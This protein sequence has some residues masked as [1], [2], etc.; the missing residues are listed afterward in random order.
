M[1]PY[2]KWLNA[3]PKYGAVA[4]R[5]PEFTVPHQPQNA[6]LS[7]LYSY[8]SCA[9]IDELLWGCPTGDSVNSPT[10]GGVSET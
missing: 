7:K 3:Q 5:V 8:Y 1:A 2:C 6:R 4:V 9:P 10:S